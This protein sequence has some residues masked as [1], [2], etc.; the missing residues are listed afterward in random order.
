MGAI[1]R[2]LANNI[3]SGGTIDA[4]DGLTGTVPA[5]NIN[6]T[7]VSAITSMPATVGDFVQ[8]VDSDPSPASEGDV[9]YNSTTGVLKSVVALAAWSSGSPLI[10]AR[11]SLSGAGTQ[12]AGLAFGGIT[13]AVTATTEEYTSGLQTRVIKV[14]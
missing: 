4:T 6:N 2:G 13:T 1:T 8:S 9:W 7:S 11:D 5:S 12:T 14:S 3:L 10:N